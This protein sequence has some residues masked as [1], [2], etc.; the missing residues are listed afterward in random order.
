MIAIA[1]LEYLGVSLRVINSLEESEYNLV[2]I[3]DLLKL[4]EQEISLIPNIGKSGVSQIFNAL[5]NLENL[6]KEKAV[7]ELIPNTIK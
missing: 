4:T 5:K 7:W 1:E 6:E 3:D 2:Y